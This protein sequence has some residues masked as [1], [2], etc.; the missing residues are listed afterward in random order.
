MTATAPPSA[1]AHSG[2]HRA[3]NR[4][5]STVRTKMKMLSAAA[6]RVPFQS[7]QLYAHSLF[8]LRSRNQ[9]H[10]TFAPAALEVAVSARAIF[11]G[12]RPIDMDV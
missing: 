3:H 12:E 6:K 1:A 5:A 10:F 9:Q 7:T 11:K 8:D 2:I 4:I